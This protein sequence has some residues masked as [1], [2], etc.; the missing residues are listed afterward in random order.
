MTK[1]KEVTDSRMLEPDCKY[2][3][4]TI[5]R[6]SCNF[7]DKINNTCCNLNVLHGMRLCPEFPPT[8]NPCQ[9]D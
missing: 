2:F 5:K 4:K 6:G 7:P 1:I 8:Y 3:V 9:K